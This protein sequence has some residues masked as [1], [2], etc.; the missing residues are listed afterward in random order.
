MR[1]GAQ[2]HGLDQRPQDEGDVFMIRSSGRDVQAGKVSLVVQS[3]ML[4]A[5]FLMHFLS[6]TPFGLSKICSIGNKMDV[7]EVDLLEYFVDD[8]NRRDLDVSRGHETRARVLRIGEKD[9]KPS[10]Y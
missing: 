3:G 10:S 9:D 2:L 4:S 8:P 7:D 6:R 1:L 5:G